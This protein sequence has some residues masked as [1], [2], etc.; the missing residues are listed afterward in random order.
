MSLRENHGTI[1]L[2]RVV[3]VPF[4]PPEDVTA[5]PGLVLLPV[6]RNRV[7]TGRESELALLR[8]ELSSG[9]TGDRPTGDRPAGDGPAVMVVH[10]MGGTGKSALALEYAHR[11]HGAHNPVVHLS[12]D[13]PERITTDLAAL[14]DALNPTLRQSDA[15]VETRADWAKGWLQCHD[16]W[17]L[18]LDDV[19]QPADA[20]RLLGSLGGRG[21]AV[22]TTRQ[23]TGW[24]RHAAVL[25][26]DVLPEEAATDLLTRLT[27]H[28]PDTP[29][30]RELAARLD[31]LPLALEQ[32]AAY[33]KQTRTGPAGY[34]RL[35]DASP[36]EALGTTAPGRSPE[37]TIARV[38]QHTMR[39]VDR[40]HPHAV[41][42]MRVLAWFAPSGI[43][44]GLL[45]QLRP[46]TSRSA[47]GRARPAL[48]QLGHSTG[49]LHH[50][51]GLAGR[52]LT[53]AD[54]DGALAVLGAYGLVRLSDDTVAVHS[55]MQTV[56][57]T[58][59]AGDPHRTRRA[60]SAARDEA[61]EL[62]AQ[63]G[64]NH[65]STPEN[66]PWWQTMAPQFE[67]FLAAAPPQTDNLWTVHV[68][69]SMVCYLRDSERPASDPHAVLHAER[70]VRLMR[71]R[72][73][74][75][76][77]HPATRDMQVHLA[78]A[79][80]RSGRTDEALRLLEGRRRR[81][82]VRPAML[83]NR[84]HALAQCYLRQGR[85]QEAL[86]L[87]EF[88][89]RYGQFDSA[90]KGA[91]RDA[92]KVRE[93]LAQA[94]GHAGRRDQAVAL[95]EEN[96]WRAM[97]A[98]GDQAPLT[99]WARDSLARAYTGIGE[100]ARAV[101]LHERT[102]AAWERTLGPRCPEAFHSRLALAHAH[103]VAGDVEAAISLLERNVA[104]ASGA[105][106]EDS[107]V[108]L[109]CR[110][111]LAASMLRRDDVDGALALHAANIADTGRIFGPH[112]IEVQQVRRDFGTD[113]L[114]T[115]HPEQAVPVLADALEGME[116]A[117]GPMGRETIAARGLL[118]A[119]LHQAGRVHEAVAL[120]EQAL[121]QALAVLHPEDPHILDV[122]L[123]VARAYRDTGDPERAASVLD[124]VA[125]EA[126]ARF[127]DGNLYEEEALRLLRDI[128]AH[129]PG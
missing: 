12:A 115:D 114:I 125:R 23:A 87:L 59:V 21:A 126:H 117:A 43:P 63:A 54:I 30:L 66:W 19:Q 28:R 67:A 83:P 75:G 13:S 109:T 72:M 85:F 123:D 47:V 110:R 98:L 106:A 38:W 60:V 22:I 45:E 34:L 91:L 100:A 51:R 15:P 119:A 64:G 80:E 99:L 92:L 81:T 3:Q 17:L 68:L 89:Y 4:L 84:R 65:P 29:E 11:Y 46:D 102:L 70:A 103:A 122:R 35:L 8:A 108:M 121:G 78:Q 120:Y 90:A 26:L 129:R 42:L 58:P 105:F 97:Q 118:A 33:I 127:E 76:R 73:L 96:L 86:P 128:G 112:H 94:H 53:P 27:G 24:D 74:G 16:G 52:R 5:H 9:T 104:L 107:P 101:D 57:R 44:R 113:L 40:E 1:N 95:R 10:G 61:A 6:G 69:W 82:A 62:L 31:R 116:D 25:A 20:V 49:L 77:L 37:R 56:A 88:E 18:L 36:A 39:A 71:R 32:A 2:T 14:A 41:H 55:L 7:F 124:R 93:L 79:L 111:M 50:R 48:R